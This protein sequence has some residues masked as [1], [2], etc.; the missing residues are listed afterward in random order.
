MKNQRDRLSLKSIVKIVVLLVVFL[1]VFLQ[2]Q[3]HLHLIDR[4]GRQKLSFRRVEP[5]ILQAV[6]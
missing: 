3:F 1:S 2:N 6:F 4:I 5:F